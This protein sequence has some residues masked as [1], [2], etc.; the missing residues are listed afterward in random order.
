MKYAAFFLLLCLFG[1]AAEPVKP[2]VRMLDF[3]C[4]AVGVSSVTFFVTSTG[5]ASISW[6]NKAACGNP[7]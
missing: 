1:C 2:E 6:S 7:T 3:E 4:D 5:V